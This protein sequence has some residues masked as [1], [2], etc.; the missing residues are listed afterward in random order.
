MY[1]SD[2]DMATSMF[3]ECVGTRRPTEGVH[4][5][6]HVATD[7]R[8]NMRLVA[9]PL[10]DTQNSLHEEQNISCIARCEALSPVGKSC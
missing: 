6:K 2:V 9:Q 3:N 10:R 5:W 4:D 8:D 1:V 7:K